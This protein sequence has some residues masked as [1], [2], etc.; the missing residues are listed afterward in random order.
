M[1]TNTN[2]N[3]NINNFI[4]LLLKKLTTQYISSTQHTSD[5]TAIHLP[6]VFLRG[7][8]DHGEGLAVKNC[9]STSVSLTHILEHFLNVHLAPVELGSLHLLHHYS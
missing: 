7:V 4:H 6:L 9:A 2:T 5:L 8:E 3:T 1:Y